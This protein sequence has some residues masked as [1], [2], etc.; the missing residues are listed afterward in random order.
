MRENGQRAGAYCDAASGSISIARGAAERFNA[1]EAS[2]QSSEAGNIWSD[3]SSLILAAVGEGI[4]GLDADGL[5]TFVNPAAEA[6]TG[7][8]AEELIG[9]SQHEILHHSYPDG[10]PYPRQDCSLYKAIRDGRVYRS[11]SEVFWR[12]DGTQFPIAYTV[13]PITRDG[14]TTGAVVVFQDI[15]ERKRT[16]A[17]GKSKT[18]ICFAITSHRELPETLGMI[19]GALRALHPALATAFFV[20]REGSGLEL[21][22]Q[23]GLPE[24]LRTVLARGL[25]DISPS[26]SRSA[27]E[28]GTEI[29][30]LQKESGLEQLPI[31]LAH[32]GFR[33]CTAIPLLSGS[34]Q[35]LGAV[36]VF[37]GESDSITEQST[38]AAIDS[39]CDLARLAIEHQQLHTE[40][41]RQSQ[42][43]HL[44][45]LPNRLLLEDRL[46]QAIAQAKRHGTQVGV[47]YIDLDR[48][49]QINDTL[50]HS[51]GDALLQHVADTLKSGLR[52]IDTVARHGGDEFI[53]VLPDL[54]GTAET[55]EV[56]ERIL[57]SLRKPVRLGKHM[58]T[59]AA[60]IG[61]SLFPAMGDSTAALLRYADTALYAAKRGGKDRVHG[62]H[63]SLG[64][65]V[66]RT[67]ELQGDL[68]TAL[69]RNEFSLVYQPLYSMRKQLKGFE[70]LLRWTHGRRGPVGPDE[71]IPIAEETALIVP[72]GMWVLREACRQGVAWNRN[73]LAPVRMY[74]NVSAVQ[75]SRPDFADSVAEVLRETGLVPQLLELEVTETSVLADTQAA[76]A[77]LARLRALGVGI[78]IDDFG[79]GYSSFGYLQQLPVNT[80]K[81]DRS[82]IARLD[83]NP[84]SSAI[85]RTIVALAEELGLETVAEGVE[86]GMQVEELENARCGLLQGYLLAKPLAPS[87][88]GLLM[89]SAPGS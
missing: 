26:V 75:L 2:Q 86:T 1:G 4:Y 66:R 33:S 39:A 51:V 36:S 62:Y 78:S 24:S 74:V 50:G 9:R 38:R 87:A 64:E 80:L 81:I 20:R 35:V 28:Q 5:T 59:P 67:M 8:K 3:A 46:D 89:E 57:G 23:A 85:V 41:L 45:G 69:E 84:A 77:R 68:R 40:L 71:F 70:A 27:A 88:A 10:I 14:Q 76:C 47:C 53:L 61:F 29:W 7:W 15:S 37:T 48:F 30:A 54:S 58:I 22:A 56:C 31:E 25:A 21:T 79:T 55:E 11:D 19:A 42:H 12:K 34:G 49:K 18:A 83:G 17:W 44:T 72:I 63:P 73:A 52:E 43:D 32:G 65:K 16:E 13:A 82:F 60:S 6:M